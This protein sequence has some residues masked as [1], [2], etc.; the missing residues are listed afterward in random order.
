[1]RS[2]R[3]PTPRSEFDGVKKRLY[4]LERRIRGLGTNDRPVKFDYAFPPF[5]LNGAISVSSSDHYP[6][7]ASCRLVLVRGLLKTS[8]SSTTTA[9]LKKNAATTVAT[10]SFTSGNTTPTT[11]PTVAVNLVDGD[12]LWLDVTGAG[13]G[14]AG[15]VVALWA[16]AA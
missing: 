16:M 6:V 15:L 8:G 7:P 5:N 11:T 14:A 4:E 13:T 12:Y 3:V 2:V 10:F 1:M 9:I